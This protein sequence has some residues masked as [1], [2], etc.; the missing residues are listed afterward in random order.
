MFIAAVVICQ[1]RKVPYDNC[2]PQYESGRR[3][4]RGEL[5][6]ISCGGVTA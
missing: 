6:K 4:C 5:E 2:A 1:N 3:E